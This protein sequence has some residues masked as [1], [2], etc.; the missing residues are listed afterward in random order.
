MEPLLHKS[1][2]TIPVKLQ[3]ED[4]KYILVHGYTGAID[5]VDGSIVDALNTDN[6]SLLLSEDEISLLS[7]RGYITTKNLEEEQNHVIR[8]ADLLHK[9]K[10]KLHKNWGF[11]ITY[12]CNFRC[13]YCFEN[14]ISKN[15][16][17]WS[18]QTMTK[19]LVDKAYEAMLKIE[20]RNELHRKEILLYGGEPLLREN[21]EIVKYI[22]TKGNCLGYRFKAITNGY[23][24]DYYSDLITKKYFDS[25]QISLDGFKNYHNKRKFHYLEG[26]SF[27]K[28]IAN[29]ATIINHDV[30][31][32]V[33]INIDNN[34]I[35]DLENLY[36]YFKEIGY[37]DSKY[38]H[39]Y[40]AKVE[41]YSVAELEMTNDEMT[42]D[43]DYMSA[44][45]FNQKLK[46][47]DSGYSNNTE[48]RIVNAFYYYL[49][50]KKRC[51]LTSVACSGQHGT[52]LFGPDGGI[53]T[54][55]ESVGKKEH[56]IGYYNEA[57]LRWTSAKDKWFCK[58]IG[59]SNF[60]KTCKFALLCGGNCSN[61]EFSCNLKK[62]LC[63]HYKNE[64]QYSVNKAYNLFKPK[65]N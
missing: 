35:S 22:V 30:H 37:S 43:I 40:A 34:N 44:D 42:N 1:H 5:I 14:T 12:N 32:S 51:T 57:V 13:P 65:T 9:A 62:T 52:H 15:G 31:V 33:R 10:L 25:V 23:D 56:C 46:E 29:I 48:Q 59:N 38:F 28:V 8:L 64:F 49:K 26:D 47:S 11:V 58:H 2:Y 4:N 27:D 3:V 60:C 21:H 39:V 24:I 41:N 63:S 54:C 17:A 61:K 20:P 50:N 55:L 53:Y 16:T 18:K 6:I 7:N 45:N 36:S 19:E